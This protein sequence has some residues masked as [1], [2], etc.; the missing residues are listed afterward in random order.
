[1]PPSLPPSLPTSDLVFIYGALRSGTTV[2]R[3]MLDHHPKIA[4]PGELDFLF[5]ELRPDATAPSGWRYD[6]KRLLAN[7]IFLSNHLSMPDA[8]DGLDLLQHFLAQIRQRTGDKPVVTINV[9]RHI[10]RILAIFPRAKIVHMLR[11]PRDV[12]R[13]SIHMGWAATLYHGVGHWVRTESAWDR[14]IRGADPAQIHTLT[15]EALFTDTEGELR[16]V[17]DLLGVEWDPEMLN[18]HANSSY[19]PPDPALIAQ[20]R[21]KCS[22]QE[23]ALLEGRAGALMTARGY[24]LN[25]KPVVP[26]LI[27]RLRLSLVQK[28]Y[29]WR[30][31]VGRYGAAPRQR[32][33]GAFER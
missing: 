12:A 16:A 4:N 33:P 5:D 31:G 25:G 21:H 24:A 29:L 30:F 17:C 10:D 3:L 19:P 6:K 26:D 20:W 9:H 11:D 28:A 14:G 18:Y 23:V 15:Y 32:C 13:S 8:L 22:A 2:F 27:G 7:R 1:M